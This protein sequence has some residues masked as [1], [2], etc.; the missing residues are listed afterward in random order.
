M[1]AAPSNDATYRFRE[2]KK[3]ILPKLSYR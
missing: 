3:R 1:A 2:F